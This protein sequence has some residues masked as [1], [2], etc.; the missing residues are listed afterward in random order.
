MKRLVTTRP[1]EVELWDDA[2]EPVVGPGDAL[3]AIEA[4]GI[5]GSDVH[6]FLGDHPYS[7]FPNVQGHEFAG[8]VLSLPGDYRGPLRVGERVAVEPLLMCGTCLPCRRG[9][10]NCCVQMRTYGAQ[11]DGAL[12]ERMAVPARL[13]YSAGGIDA[14]VAALV[15]PYSIGMHAVARSGLEAGDTAVVYGAGPIG[16]T[17]L[18]AAVDR[19]ARVL[20]VDSLPGRLALAHVLGADSTVAVGAGRSAD[21]Q[22]AEWTSGDGPVVVFE[23]TGSPDVLRSAIEVVAPSGTVVIV[24]LSKQPVSVPMV[25]FTRKELT[26]IGSRNNMGVFGKAAAMVARDPERA[27]RLITHRFTLDRAAEAFEVALH[28][29]ETTEK[30]VISIK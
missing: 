18:S 26:V 21:D 16:L 23:A 1:G 11:I 20:M 15:E 4:V 6:L 27:R 13:L 3:I 24:G 8:T 9:R 7:H 17:I 19:G 29:P 30:V 28:S 5:C 12:T 10:G 22:I 25:H 2:P 14:E